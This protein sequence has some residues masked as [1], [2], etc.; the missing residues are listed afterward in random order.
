MNVEDNVGRAAIQ[1]LVDDAK[2]HYEAIALASCHWNS[3]I[4]KALD[5]YAKYAE[6]V[7]VPDA[8]IV[9]L[10]ANIRKEV[11]FIYP[12]WV[13]VILICLGRAAIRFDAGEE[14]DKLLPY[15]NQNVEVKVYPKGASHD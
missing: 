5:F 4:P 13:E 3:L 9:T 15:A 11:Q 14:C 7:P 6:T 8:P 10:D 1:E 2:K 12:H